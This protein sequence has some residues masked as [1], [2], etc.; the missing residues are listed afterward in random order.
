M[1]EQMKGIDF[2]HTKKRYKIGAY[3][4]RKG[5]H[6]A[7]FAQVE[8]ATGVLR[9]TVRDILDKAD[10]AGLVSKTPFH[11][12]KKKGFEVILLPSFLSIADELR[13]RCMEAHDKEKVEDGA[14]HELVKLDNDDYEKLWPELSSLGWGP[15]LTSI[16]IERLEKRGMSVGGLKFSFDHIEYIL[17]TNPPNKPAKDTIM[18]Y[19]RSLDHD[20]YLPMPSGYVPAEVLVLIE[21]NQ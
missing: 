18:H 2:F 6:K 4:L 15:E 14:I 20:G 21:S 1:S 16:L 19:F 5:S 13:M 11:E 10:Q 3:L 17:V 7:T 8:K 12:G 9:R